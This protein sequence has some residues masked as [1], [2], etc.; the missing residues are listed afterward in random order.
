MGSDR[1]YSTSLKIRC[2]AGM[3]LNACGEEVSALSRFF[4][5]F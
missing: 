3:A 4:R 1:H 5:W 2:G